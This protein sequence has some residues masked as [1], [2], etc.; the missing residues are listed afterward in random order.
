MKQSYINSI[1]NL[2]SIEKIQVKNTI[3]L[4]SEGATVPF[5][6]RYRKEMTGSLDEVQ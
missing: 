5:I 2:L 6:S 1:S 3:N 4:L